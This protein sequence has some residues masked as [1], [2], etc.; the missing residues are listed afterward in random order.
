MS[1]NDNIRLV[2]TENAMTENALTEIAIN[3]DM[4]VELIV[5]ISLISGIIT[6]FSISNTGYFALQR[7][8]Q[9][10]ITPTS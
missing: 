6:C 1:L 2:L 10:I 8:D 5:T 3:Q 7:V 4:N 9:G